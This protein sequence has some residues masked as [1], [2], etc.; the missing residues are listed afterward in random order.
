LDFLK[1]DEIIDTK[2]IKK[3]VK[4]N[5]KNYKNIVVLGI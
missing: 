5:K 2:K 3:F 1:V 4:K